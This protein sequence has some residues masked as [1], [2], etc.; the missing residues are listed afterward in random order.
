MVIM[1]FGFYFIVYLYICKKTKKFKPKSSFITKKLFLVNSGLTTGPNKQLYQICSTFDEFS[2]IRLQS[3]A[4]HNLV[5]RPQSC[6]Y[7][8][9][10][11]YIVATQ[12]KHRYLN[13]FKN[14]LVPEALLHC[15]IV[16][17][18]LLRAQLSQ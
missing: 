1:P 2:N 17:I 4:Q 5:F 3:W 18:N 16:V 7:C 11:I 8:K 15:R 14:I 13:F 10:T 12:S 6:F 9:I